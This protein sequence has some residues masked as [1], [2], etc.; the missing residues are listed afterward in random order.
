MAITNGGAGSGGVSGTQTSGNTS[1]S[2]GTT[3]KGSPYDAADLNK[4]SPAPAPVNSPVSEY[5]NTHNQMRQSYFD[6]S[7]FGYQGANDS[8][9]TSSQFSN[10]NFPSAKNNLFQFAILFIIAFLIFRKK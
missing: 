9:Q 4:T 8:A 1:T 10:Q 2:S 5:I 6:A 7:S 3:G